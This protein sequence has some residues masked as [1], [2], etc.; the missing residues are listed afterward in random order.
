M[1]HINTVSILG[2]ELYVMGKTTS[3]SQVFGVADPELVS[4]YI[5]RVVRVYHRQVDVGFESEARRHIPQDVKA[6][7]WQR[8]G[9]KCVQC[10]ATDYLE[11][12]HVIPYAKGGANTAENVQLL[13]RRCN[14]AKSDS[15]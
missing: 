10:G 7:V 3:A 6:A 8:D 14:L 9:G 5:R 4:A 11:Y 13:C 15:I 2:N 1:S 12:D